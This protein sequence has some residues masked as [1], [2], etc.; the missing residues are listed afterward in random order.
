VRYNVGM[1]PSSAEVDEPAIAWTEPTLLDALRSDLSGTMVVTRTVRA[2]RSLRQRYGQ[3]Q[4]GSGRMGWMSPRILAWEPW[5]ATLWDAVILAC[6][7]SRMLVTDAQ[8]LELW[9]S[10]LVDDSDA[11]QTLSSESVAEAAHAAWK[12]MHLYEIPPVR[13]RGEQSLD[14]RAFYRWATEMETLCR[15]SSFLPSSRLEAALVQAI[16]SA[17][18]RLPKRIFLIGFDRVIPTQRRLIEALAACGY[19]IEWVEM[20]PE[21]FVKSDAAIVYAGTVAEEIRAAAQWIRRSLFK[22]PSQRIGVVVPS[23]KEMRGEIDRTFRHVLVPSAMEIATGDV[24]LPYEFSLGTA[25]FQLP[26]IRTA[27]TLL[28]WLRVAIPAEEVSWLLVHGDFGGAPEESARARLDRRF[29][30]REFQLGGPVSLPSFQQ[31]L[32]HTGRGE[33]TASLRRAVERFSIAAHRA[34][35]DAVHSYADWSE[36]VEDVLAAAEWRL[37]AAGSSGEVQL[38]RRWDTLLA[39]M[40]SLTGVAGPVPFGAMTKRLEHLAAHTLFALETRNAPVQIVGVAESAGL[41]FD[42]V[43]WM[44]AQVG[45]W[46]VRGAAQPF[47]PWGLQREAHMPYADPASDFAFA[48]RTTQRILRCGSTVVVSFAVEQSDPVNASA[49]V[50]DR[51][52]LLSPLVRVALPDTPTIA[53]EEFLAGIKFNPDAPKQEFEAI[54]E[55]PAVP[56]LAN[57]V[58]GGVSFLELHA[59]CPFRAFAELR[60]GSRPLAE[61]ETGVS[62]R[63]Q[64]TIVHRVLERFW[65]DTKSQTKLLASTSDEHRECLRRHIDE[66]LAEFL[67]HADEPWQRLLLQ[68]EAER[69]EQRLLEW[70]EQEKQRADFTVLEIENALEHPRLGEIEFRCRV[71]RIDRVAEGIVL[72]DYK[73]GPVDR[74]AC[75]GERPDQPQLPAYAVLRGGQADG[76]LAGVAFAG[77]EPRNVGFT[78]IGS[79]PGI[80]SAPPESAKATPPGKKTKSNA[81]ALTPEEMLLQQRAWS[82]VLTR[83][84]EEFRAGIAVVDPKKQEKTCLYCAQKPL[85]RIREAAGAGEP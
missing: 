75:D 49:H 11:R 73:T 10:L 67:E 71:D 54:H 4:R 78:V 80:F 22:N 55:E 21:G 18:I 57:Q 53:V 44:N 82:E 32:A 6:E 47:L 59:A 5:L 40:A 85:C 72:L 23:L 77:L 62:P 35:L 30:E 65:Q 76:A 14:G 38:Q 46:P 15:Q 83:L 45:A 68:V 50:P 69:L 79:L 42:A 34:G 74:N 58:S 17:H 52:I 70:L 28:R 12:Q 36:I 16:S 2:A 51:E 48:L 3:R 26:P 9:R 37:P 7:E 66:A 56:F 25:M 13:L 63:T 81:A 1:F 19:S 43:W 64:G 84:A 20:Q 8:E 61:P 33:E 27:L 60:L 29:R 41:A 39:E 31:W 24:P